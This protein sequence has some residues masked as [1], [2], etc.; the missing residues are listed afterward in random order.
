[1]T[2]ICRVRNVQIQSE[3]VDKKVYFLTLFCPLNPMEPLEFRSSWPFVATKLIKSGYFQ[4]LV[5]SG[6]YWIHSS[7]NLMLNPMV[8]MIFRFSVV[9]VVFDHQESVRFE[10][11]LV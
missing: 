1:M 8:P 10:N 7:P 6:R 9:L 2:S 11:E 5:Y 4:I 3:V